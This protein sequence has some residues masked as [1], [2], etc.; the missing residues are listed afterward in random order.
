[1]R[2]NDFLQEANILNGDEIRSLLN[3]IAKNIPD[4]YKKRFVNI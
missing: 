4:P 1:M 3:D 2:L